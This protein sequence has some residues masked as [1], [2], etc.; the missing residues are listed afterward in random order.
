MN[1]LVYFYIHLTFVLFLGETINVLVK[2]DRISNLFSLYFVC[3]V[4]LTVIGLLSLIYVTKNK[5]N[6]SLNS[7][8]LF[9]R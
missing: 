7:F 6:S 5:P 3:L 9:L 8:S 4:L 2:A 1:K